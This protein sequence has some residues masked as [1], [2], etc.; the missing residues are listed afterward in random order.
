VSPLQRGRRK[1]DH[2]YEKWVLD[3]FL[4]EGIG[5]V[6]APR[7]YP[8]RS[9][10]PPD[11]ATVRSV[12]LWNVDS[13]GD[14]LWATPVLR[15][16][17]A[18]YHHAT[19]TLVNN[20]AC[21]SLAETNRNV[22]R[23]VAID[24][25]PFC[26]GE[27]LIRT[28]PELERKPFDVMIILEMGARPADAAR[29]L[30]RR[31]G[32]GYMV[33]SDLGILKTLPDHTLPPNRSEYWPRYFLRTVEHLGLETVPPDLEVTTAPED[34]AVAGEVLSADAIGG[35]LAVG[36]HPYVASYA[37]LTKKWPDASFV[38][39]AGLLNARH[40]CRFV[41]TGSKD[42]AQECARL[43]AQIRR[44]TGADVVSLA[45]RLSLRAV[46]A[47]FRRLSVVVTGDTCALHL[48]AAAATPTVSLFGS[49]DDRRIAPPTAQC[50]VLNERLP[51]SPC[52]TYLERRLSWPRCLFDHPRCMHQITPAVVCAAV[53]RLV[54]D[55]PL[56]TAKR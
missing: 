2:L 50:V 1:V 17:R 34:E 9:A 41:L 39:L 54:F 8:R 31:L 22:D 55:A 46:V 3:R 56:T 49:T 38:A 36:F 25:A 10:K 40:R 23:L 14:F 37:R 30:G 32:V 45:G 33:S 53:Q 7:L 6:L 52:H 20:R 26:T 21:H 5:P 27:G 48:A 44:T 12:L 42:E 11:P 35:R 29:V 43:A 28:V 47:L 4:A 15:A 18:G 51:C 13:P 19:I 24:P 16:L